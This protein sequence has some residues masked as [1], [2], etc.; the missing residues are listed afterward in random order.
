MYNAEIK[1]IVVS[2]GWSDETLA[3]LA[4]DFIRERKLESK[5]INHLY[6]LQNEEKY[7]YADPE[8]DADPKWNADHDDLWDDAYR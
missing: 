4:L 5:F 2:Q 3:K 1:E 6:D 8:W 7:L